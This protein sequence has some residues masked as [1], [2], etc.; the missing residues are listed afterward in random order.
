MSEIKVEEW[1]G[2]LLVVMFQALKLQSNSA[3]QQ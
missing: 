3:C 2:A 1:E